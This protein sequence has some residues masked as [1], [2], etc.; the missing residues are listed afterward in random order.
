MGTWIAFA[1]LL[2]P[3]KLLMH[4]LL[5]FLSRPI[6][7]QT[8]VRCPY[9]HI[10][11]WKHLPLKLCAVD[12]LLLF[13]SFVRL[14]FICKISIFR[15]IL[16]KTCN[17]FIN[18]NVSLKCISLCDFYLVVPSLLFLL[19]QLDFCFHR[20]IIEIIE[21]LMNNLFNLKQNIIS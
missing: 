20:T 4:T 18:V 6:V 8:H 7:C 10:I 16:W 15:T 9:T 1:I 13:V 14:F 21:Q 17:Q 12:D 5:K 11:I 3:F 2:A 19:F